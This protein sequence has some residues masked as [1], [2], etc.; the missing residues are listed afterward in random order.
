[1]PTTRGMPNLLYEGDI[2][3]NL[4]RYE[5]KKY[6]GITEPPFKTRYGNHKKSFNKIAYKA[7]TALSKEVWEI[8]SKGGT[9]NIKWRPIRQHPSYNPVTGK[10]ALCLSEKLEILEHKQPNLLN[11]RSEIVS[12]CRHRRKY[13]LSSIFDVT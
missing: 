2:S 4:P 1:M 13:M 11:K 9:Y 10:C 8:K 7:E 3:S 5:N 6:K 12:T